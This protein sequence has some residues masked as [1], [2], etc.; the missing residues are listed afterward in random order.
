[1]DIIPAVEE[2]LIDQFNVVVAEIQVESFEIIKIVLNYYFK[3]FKET[4][5]M[6][7]FLVF[8]GWY[9]I[10]WFFFRYLE[11]F[12]NHSHYFGVVYHQKFHLDTEF[13]NNITWVSL[14]AG[15]NSPP[16][17][18][19]HGWQWY[20]TGTSALALIVR[21]RPSNSLILPVALFDLYNRH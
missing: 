16:P 4:Y 5:F 6:K 19:S 9:V 15:V 1:M 2:T 14:P 10:F 13:M 3:Q 17:Y 8:H 11:Y 18:L 20:S 12:H 7:S 21:S